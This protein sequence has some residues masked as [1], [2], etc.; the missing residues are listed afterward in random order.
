MCIVN[1]VIY[2][3]IQRR[4]SAVV[5]CLIV[6]W[7]VGGLRRGPALQ[8]LYVIKCPKRRKPVSTGFSFSYV[9]ELFASNILIKKKGQ[10]Q[11]L[12]IKHTI[13]PTHIIS[14]H[15]RAPSGKQCPNKFTCSDHNTT[16]LPLPSGLNRIIRGQPH[17][18]TLP[19]ATMSYQY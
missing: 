9:N 18:W 4:I 3:F 6:N 15:A 5:V 7:Q 2:I 14:Y 10:M 12:L 13:R 17:R 1:S 19:H 11:L 8:T 16:S